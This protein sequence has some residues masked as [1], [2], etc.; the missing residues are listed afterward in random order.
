MLNPFNYATTK[1]TTYDDLSTENSKYILPVDKFLLMV[2]EPG[3]YIKF[4]RIF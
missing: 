3:I 4:N 2:N 1:A